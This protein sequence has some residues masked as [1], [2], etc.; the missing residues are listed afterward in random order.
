M[1]SPIRA[2][3]HVMLALTSRGHVRR[4]YRF[5]DPL[6]T[7]GRGGSGGRRRARDGVALVPAGVIDSALPATGAPLPP[8]VGAPGPAG[9]A[10]RASDRGA[11]R[12]GRRGGRPRHD[13]RDRNG[14]H[15]VDPPPRDAGRDAAL[16]TRSLHRSSARLPEALEAPRR[17]A[18]GGARH[19][20]R[21]RAGRDM[22]RALRRPHLLG[23]AVRQGAPGARGGPRGLRRRRALDRGR[24]LDRLAALRP[25]DAQRVHGRLQGTLPGRLVPLRLV[26]PRRSTRTSQTSSADWSTGRSP[27]WANAPGS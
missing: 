27:R 20:R 8:V 21:R 5:R 12:G 19:R 2:L 18:A 13:R 9:L 7:R 22:A 10:D 23:V 24:R 4:G 11:R 16:P 17:P 1:R 14:L 25:R 15:R 6:G 26:P 3:T